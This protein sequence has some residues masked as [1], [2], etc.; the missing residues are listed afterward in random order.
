MYLCLKNR[1]IESSLMYN[2]NKAGYVHKDQKEASWTQ[3][4]STHSC[5]EFTKHV[6]V[7][8]VINFLFD[9]KVGRS[10]TVIKGWTSFPLLW[11][12]SLILKKKYGNGKTCK[13]TCSFSKYLTQCDSFVQLTYD[14]WSH[15]WLIKLTFSQLFF[16]WIHSIIISEMMASV[17][18]EFF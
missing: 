3:S 11:L 16:L 13:T 8:F 10:T 5:L 14:T 4:V 12:Y 2:K 15:L 7:R 1:F 17:W 18:V 9:L 6:M